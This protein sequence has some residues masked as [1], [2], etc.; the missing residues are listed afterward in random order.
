MTRIASIIDE[1]NA[2]ST[3]MAERPGMAVDRPVT[4]D[5]TPARLDARRLPA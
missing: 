3:A 2:R 5:G 1:D 4:V